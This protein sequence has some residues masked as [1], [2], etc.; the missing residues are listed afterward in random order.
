MMSDSQPESTSV[1]CETPPTMFSSLSPLNV[2]RHDLHENV[3]WYLSTLLSIDNS[4]ELTFF[5]DLHCLTKCL[6]FTWIACF[7]PSQALCNTSVMRFP[8]TSHLVQ[9]S[10][11]LPPHVFA[12]AFLPVLPCCL[13][14]W[15]WNFFARLWSA[16]ISVYLH[17]H[18]QPGRH[19]HGKILTRHISSYS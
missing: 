18:K 13:L 1:A 16:E 14:L 17:F 15:L 8:P 2:G 7:I 6:S 5:P 10:T 9:C 4:T 11:D 3:N 12:T 19:R